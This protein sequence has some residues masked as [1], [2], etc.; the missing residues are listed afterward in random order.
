M[1]FAFTACLVTTSDSLPVVGLGLG[2][3]Y[4]TI[5]SN[6]L[7]LS[8]LTHG[9]FTVDLVIW[10]ALLGGRSSGSSYYGM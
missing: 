6:K 2:V 4:C 1:V 5:E 7:V 10:V 8:S 9:S 3:I